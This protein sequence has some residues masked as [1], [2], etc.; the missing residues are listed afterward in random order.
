MHEYTD[1]PEY[2]RTTIW[3]CCLCIIEDVNLRS[4]LRYDVK[5]NITSIKKVFVFTLQ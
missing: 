4:N 1:K 3:H 2:H 5:D